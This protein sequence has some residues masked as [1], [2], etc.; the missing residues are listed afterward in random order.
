M[1]QIIKF[2]KIQDLWYAIL[3]EYIEAGGDF[4]DCLMV[5]GAPEML[6]RLSNNG[7]EITLVLSNKEMDYDC[8]LSKY[9]EESGWGFYLCFFGAVKDKNRFHVGLCPVNLFVWGGRHPEIIYV[10]IKD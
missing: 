7:D 9:D 8:R 3:P 5:D 4:N 10:K 2:E 1:G 6:D